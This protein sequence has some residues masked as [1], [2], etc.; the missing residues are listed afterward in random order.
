VHCE[1][2]AFDGASFI[3]SS[4]DEKSRWRPQN[5]D[6]GGGLSK[7]EW[8]YVDRTGVKRLSSGPLCA[9]RPRHGEHLLRVNI[10]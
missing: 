5:Q 9:A 1:D 7:Y 4:L 3:L 10:I 2:V 6:L 8:F